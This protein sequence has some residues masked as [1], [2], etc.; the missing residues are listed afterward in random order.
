MSPEDVWQVG[1]AASQ[2]NQHVTHIVRCKTLVRGVSMALLWLHLIKKKFTQM[3]KEIRGTRNYL[4]L[5][6]PDAATRLNYKTLM[7]K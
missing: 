3:K 1:G 6:T 2:P 5:M 4:P 7:N